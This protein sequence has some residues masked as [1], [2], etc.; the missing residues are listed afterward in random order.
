MNVLIDKLPMSVRIGDKVYAIR[1]DFRVCL[2]IMLAFEDYGLTDYEKSAVMLNLLYEEIPP[3]L[4]SAMRLAVKF[5]DGGMSTPQQDAENRSCDEVE[6]LFSFSHDA[7]RIY[8]AFRS[9]Y[10]IDLSAVEYMHWWTFMSL[11][12][13]LGEDCAFNNLVA[14]RKRKRDGKLTKEEKQMWNATPELFE[15]PKAPDAE[16]DAAIAEFNKRLGIT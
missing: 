2:K 4:E 8:S 11:F 13:D 14:L 1:T 15:L 6:R 12:M 9:T 3:D 7:N 5:L 16:R 10:G